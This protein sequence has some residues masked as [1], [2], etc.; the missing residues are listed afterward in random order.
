MVLSGTQEHHV[1]PRASGGIDGPTVDLCGTC[2]QTVHDA[3]KRMSKGK[4]ADDKLAHLDELAR[5]RAMVLVQSILA[6]LLYGTP[7]SNVMLS[8]LL[9]DPLY[10]RALDKFKLDR[11]FSSREKAINAI[12]KTL[13]EGYGLI[14]NKQLK[15][16]KT[17]TLAQFRRGGLG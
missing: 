9:D 7:D 13:A 6:A 15:P 10:L 16:S 17:T 5:S 2:H 3:A 12:L 11:G 1:L 8:V 14:E 4:P